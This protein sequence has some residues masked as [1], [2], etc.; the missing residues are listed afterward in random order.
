[1]LWLVTYRAVWHHGQRQYCPSPGDGR[2]YEHRSK[3]LIQ[4]GL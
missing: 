3:R 1:M 4:S 2:D